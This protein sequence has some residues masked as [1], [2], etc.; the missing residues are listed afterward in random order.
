MKNNVQEIKD[1]LLAK[2][3]TVSTAESIT[4]GHLQAMLSSISGASDF[5][6]GGITA[7]QRSVKVDVLGVDDELAKATDCV[8][9]AIAQQMAQ[10]ALKLF[11]TNYAIATCGYAEKENGKPYAFF[12]IA[13]ASGTINHGERVDLCGGRVEAQ[14]QTA[15]RALERYEELLEKSTDRT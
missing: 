4:A 6:Q 5:F 15:R 10:G 9:A 1:L 13:D 11:K 2:G 8:D 14:E 3:K 12:A 7:Y